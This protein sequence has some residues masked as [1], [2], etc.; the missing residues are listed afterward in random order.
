MH[1]ILLIAGQDL[2]RQ[3]NTDLEVILPGTCIYTVLIT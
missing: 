1:C 2:V 3:K